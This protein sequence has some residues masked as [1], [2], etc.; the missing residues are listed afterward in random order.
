MYT[1][2]IGGGKVGYYLAKEL[3]DEGHEVLVIERDRRKAERVARRE[4]EREAREDR[5]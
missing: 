5:Y 4:A 3:V 2:I 1:I